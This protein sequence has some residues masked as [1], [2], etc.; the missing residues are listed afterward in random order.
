MLLLLNQHLWLLLL[1]TTIATSFALFQVVTIL[2]GIVA[3]TVKLI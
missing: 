1:L 2:Y 3:T